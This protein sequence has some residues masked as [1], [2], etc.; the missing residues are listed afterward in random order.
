MTTR[1]DYVAVD[2]K[3]AAHVITN[4][5][6]MDWE[7]I[8]QQGV[9][10]DHRP[11]SC[12]VK[13]PLLQEKCGVGE[14]QRQND[15]LGMTTFNTKLTRAYTAYIE[16]INNGMRMD[17]K[18]VDQEALTNAKLKNTSQLIGAPN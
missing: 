9:G 13:I 12:S 1:I 2:G 11:V 6:A 17:P 4:E 16:D 7:A 3:M 10:I 5:G 18:P 14:R 15:K 8:G